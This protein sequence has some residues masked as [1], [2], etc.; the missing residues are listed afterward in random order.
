MQFTIAS[1]VSWVH[2]LIIGLG[3]D[4]KK[5]KASLVFHFIEIVRDIFGNI[6]PAT[7]KAYTIINTKILG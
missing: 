4:T 1:G 6:R 7:I 2:L 5:N 3:L